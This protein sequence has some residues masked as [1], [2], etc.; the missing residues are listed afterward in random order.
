M[1]LALIGFIIQS[2]VSRKRCFAS[3]LLLRDSSIP[4][5]EG[6][7]LVDV[8][9]IRECDTPDLLP[10]ACIIT[11]PA[12]CVQQRCSCGQLLPASALLLCSTVRHRFLRLL[13]HEL[14]VLRTQGGQPWQKRKNPG[15]SRTVELGPTGPTCG[16]PRS[17][18]ISGNRLASKLSFLFDTSLG[19]LQFLPPSELSNRRHSR[20]RGVNTGSDALHFEDREKILSLSKITT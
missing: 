4:F 1:W 15:R 12:Y 19:Y 8:R 20:I 14:T 16:P 13:C 5:L 6:I 2:H 11:Q 9:L 3:K 10:G 17:H 18:S 7:L